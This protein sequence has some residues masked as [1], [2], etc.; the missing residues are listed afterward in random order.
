M[1]RELLY[2]STLWSGKYQNAD[3]RLVG[4]D[5][6]VEHSHFR[7]ERYELAD[8]FTCQ[9]AVSDRSSS[10]DIQGTR[11]EQPGL[12]VSGDRRS[13]VIVFH[14][15]RIA[16]N[17]ISDGN[18]YEHSWRTVVDAD[19][20]GRG[21]AQLAV[22]EWNKRVRRPRVISKQRLNPVGVKVFLSAQLAVYAWA[23]QSGKQVPEKVLRELETRAETTEIA[24]A[25][26]RVQKTGEPFVIEGG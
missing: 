17:F 9:L 16:A 1:P 21:L 12:P 6:T 22:L 15:D 26:A 13:G 24:E 10:K 18:M 20:R 3:P 11:V 2:G 23:V 7:C 19:Y 25:M 5:E 14:G 8:G 4:I